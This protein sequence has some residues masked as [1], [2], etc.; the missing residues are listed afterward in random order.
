MTGRL[1]PQLTSGIGVNQ[2]VSQSK[3]LLTFQ[4]TERQSKEEVKS[5]AYIQTPPLNNKRKTYRQNVFLQISNDPLF[6][7]YSRGYILTNAKKEEN[8]KKFE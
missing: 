2:L 5:L 4:N 7:V 6:A 1:K 8:T 3:Q